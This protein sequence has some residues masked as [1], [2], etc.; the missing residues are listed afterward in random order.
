MVDLDTGK[1]K[2]FE[3]ANRKKFILDENKKKDSKILFNQGRTR[4][5]IQKVDIIK[6]ED[7]NDKTKKENI[8]QLEQC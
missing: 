6:K 1:K 5:K 3:T 8:E 7:K 4:P 2:V